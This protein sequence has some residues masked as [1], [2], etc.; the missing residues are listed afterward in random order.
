[1]QRQICA[2]H[3][4]AQSAVNYG[5]LLA[6][7]SPPSVWCQLLCRL[8]FL[9]A[10]IC[11][12]M[13]AHQ[14]VLWFKTQQAAKPQPSGRLMHGACPVLSPQGIFSWVCSWCSVRTPQTGCPQ[15]ST[16]Q[17]Q[18]LLLLLSCA[19]SPMAR[20]LYILS[21]GEAEVS[22]SSFTRHLMSAI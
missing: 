18:L 12:N 6:R 13:L 8:V 7:P 21:S 2:Y 14:P 10:I 19:L 15:H 3:S 16:T 1:M 4:T 22:S 5:V 11:D 20:A 9:V 17:Q